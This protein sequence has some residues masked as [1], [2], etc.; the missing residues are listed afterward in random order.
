[1]CIG[2][3]YR[4]RACAVQYVLCYAIQPFILDATN[5]RAQ[6]S[7]C[8]ILHGGRHTFSHRS[9][10][11]LELVGTE[12]SSSFLRAQCCRPLWLHHLLRTA[13]GATP[14][15][16]NLERLPRGFQ[17]GGRAAWNV[18]CRQQAIGDEQTCI[19]RRRRRMQLQ[20]QQQHPVP[21]DDVQ[22]LPD[23]VFMQ[24][25]RRFHLMAE[26]MEMRSCRQRRRDGRSDRQPPSEPAT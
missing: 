2:L 23:E 24:P 21:V 16:K 25:M 20:R 15:E 3:L 7:E 13:I 9:S 22:L 6:G 17:G 8:K 5:A 1:M 12:V 19:A 26:V 4:P 18:T 14:P 10:S 11:A